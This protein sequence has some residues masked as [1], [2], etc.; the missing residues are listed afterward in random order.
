ME[1]PA[2]FD[3]STFPA[4]RQVAL[5]RF[6][7]V[8]VM[9]VFF[10]ILVACG[11]LMWAN[12][13]SKIHPFLISVNQV[14][15]QWEIVGHSHIRGHEIKAAQSLQESVIY[16]FIQNWFYISS[17]D[18]VNQ[19]IWG[20]CSDRKVTCGRDNTSSTEV[21]E[22]ALYC[23]ATDD[24]YDQFVKNTLPNYQQRFL[25]GEVWSADMLTLQLKPLTAITPAGNT[26]QFRVTVVSNQNSKMDIFGI[27]DISNNKQIFAPSLGYHVSGFYAYKVNK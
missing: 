6:L 12:R 2:D 17:D 8:A 18:S 11:L 14:T 1:Y 27:I 3:T 9:S 4:G 15:G 16:K 24:L 22:C 19:A 20:E 10:M 13:S 25:R 5:S 26:W 21:K 7:G 23:I